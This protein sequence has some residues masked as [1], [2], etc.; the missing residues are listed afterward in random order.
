MRP[1]SGTDF[2]AAV[3]GG[4]S[5]GT[6]LYAPAKY[7]GVTANAVAPASG[8]TSLAGEITTGTLARA[9]A[10]YAHTAGVASYTLSNVFT[11]DQTVVLA[12]AGV[13]N[14]TTA[15]TLVFEMPINPTASL[16]NQDQSTLTFTIT[17]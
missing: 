1:A 2:Q 4:A 9:L 17:L 6:G 5:N 15:G 8:D 12:K 10:T 7:I 3:M 11:S 16:I 14:A 13:F